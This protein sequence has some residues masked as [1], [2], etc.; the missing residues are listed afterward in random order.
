K[1]RDG[2]YNYGLLFAQIATSSAVDVPQSAFPI[3]HDTAKSCHNSRGYID[4]SYLFPVSDNSRNAWKWWGIFIAIS[5]GYWFIWTGFYIL[6]SKIFRKF[7]DWILPN[8]RKLCPR[9]LRKHYHKIF[10]AF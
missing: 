5:F 3:Y 8:W 9:W 2:I 4:V 1:A 10:I 7:R 6:V